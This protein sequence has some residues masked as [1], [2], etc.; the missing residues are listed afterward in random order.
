MADDKTT[1]TP[2]SFTVTVNDGANA[3]ADYPIPEASS[4]DYTWKGKGKQ[5]LKYTA[6]AEYLPIYSD[7]G[8][9]IGHMF[10]LSYVTDQQDKTDRPVTF[11]WNGG[12]GGNSVMVNVGGL[13]PR[14][15]PIKTLENLPQPTQP[16]DNP[17]SILPDTDLVYLDAMGTGYSKIAKSYDSKKVWGVY[18]DADAFMRG[19]ARWLTVHERWN[20]PLYL[21]GESYGTMR[22]AVLMRLL[23][24]RGI[25][26]T[27]VIEQSTILDYAYTLSGNDLYYMGMLPVYAATANHF[28]KAGKGVDQFEWFDKACDFVDEKYGAAL[29]KSDRITEREEKSIAR[30]MSRLIGLPANVIQQ[31]HLRIEL[32]TFRKMLLADEGLFTGRYDMRFTEPAYMDVQGDN[33][34][35]AGEDPSGDAI[36]TPDQSSFMKLVHETG[37]KGDPLNTL[38]SFDVNMDWN[39]THQA[40]GTMGS[41]SCPNTAYDM[42]TALRRNPKCRVLFFGGIHDAATPFWNVKHAISKMFLPDCLK[43][44]IEYHVHE[45]GHMAY[46]DLPTLEKMAP[47]LHAFYEKRHEN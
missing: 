23:G 42:G 4:R 45:N 3:G 2:K 19:I 35:F 46:E 33:E 6:T 22:N 21:Y 31:K 41:P 39:W 43:E 30:E 24:E 12:P 5:T 28:G 27:G 8:E 34:F 25:G 37:F 47:E 20:A 11:C 29:I 15:V 14:H 18:G 36:M 16:E 10:G 17:Y 44:R 9:L 7:D 40:P 1:Q 38:L 13:G 26:V 32:D